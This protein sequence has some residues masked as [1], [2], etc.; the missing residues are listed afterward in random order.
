[1]L[2]K[3]KY[4]NTTYKIDEEIDFPANQKLLFYF[5]CFSPFFICGIIIFVFMQGIMFPMTLLF[6]LLPI[7]VGFCFVRIFYCDNKNAWMSVREQYLSKEQRKAVL[8]SDEGFYRLCREN[9]IT[10]ITQR[11]DMERAKLLANREGINS[12]EKEIKVMFKT[13]EKIVLQQEKNQRI[14]GLMKE[15]KE[16]ENKNIEY[17]NFYGI[18]KLKRYCK[19]KIS[20][21]E[22]T[23][24]QCI[25]DEETIRNGG[26]VIYNSS[27]QKETDWA[28]AGGIASG[29]G[30][31]G[32]GISTALNAQA[33]NAEVR[34]N[35]KN[36]ARSI[37]QVQVATLQQVWETKRI[38]KS[39]LEYW[40][41]KLQ[42]AEIT[43]VE[44]LPQG[45][46]LKELNPSVKEIRVSES[47]AVRLKLV[48]D[49]PQTLKIFD[50]VP[51]YID[52]SFKAV[53]KA[54]GKVVGNAYVSLPYNGSN[55]YSTIDAV[56]RDVRISAEKYDVS[57]EANNLWA[58]EIK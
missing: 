58:M 32:A 27:K 52:G 21:C 46:L 1:M 12:N 9:S 26:E 36:L 49:R 3:Y 18:E 11:A 56:C 51:A 10:D 50:N 19:H 45:I 14:A 4:N 6:G 28:I 31:I 37:A 20:E 22:A 40:Q 41:K 5:L 8:S 34:S 44:K 42:E 57:F 7:I 33:R 48:Y 54:N 35:N 17:I 47:G 29:L 2:K 53:L 55:G 38:A 39:N 24:R 23:I 30:G 16:I 25:R 13:G 15:E 43:L